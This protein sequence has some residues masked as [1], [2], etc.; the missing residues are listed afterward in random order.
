MMCLPCS[1]RFFA[2]MELW[3]CYS[4]VVAAD[5]DDLAP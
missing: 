1:S 5:D 4:A 2:L 3:A